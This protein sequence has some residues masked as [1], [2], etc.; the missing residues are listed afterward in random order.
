[1]GQEYPEW[2]ESSETEFWRVLEWH[3]RQDP[4]WL[5]YAPFRQRWM[6]GIAP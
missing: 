3:Q 1:M 6:T 4:A 5:Y 2:L